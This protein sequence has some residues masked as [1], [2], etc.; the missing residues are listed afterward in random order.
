M[1]L[2]E[3]LPGVDIT[4]NPPELSIKLQDKNGAHA[5]QWTFSLVF[6]VSKLPLQA[7]IVI[8]N[9]VLSLKKV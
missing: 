2:V 6:K 5:C 9:H 3:C 1:Q 8:T 4:C 7:F